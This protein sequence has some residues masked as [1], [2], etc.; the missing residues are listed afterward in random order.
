MKNDTHRDAIGTS[1]P[2]I[3]AMPIERALGEL[4]TNAERGLT[5]EKARRRFELTSAK[6]LRHS[7][8]ARH[9]AVLV[10]KSV[11]DGVSHNLG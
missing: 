4:G 9:E 1:E 11:E 3:E 10:V 6:I 7:C 5:T 2:S 8:S